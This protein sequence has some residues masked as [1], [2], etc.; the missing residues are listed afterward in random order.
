M[1]RGQ[2]LSTDGSV[3]HSPEPKIRNLSDL[4]PNVSP[5]ALTD[6]SARTSV[7]PSDKNQ[8]DTPQ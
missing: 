5:T 7:P 8:G 2:D 1:A 6:P 3:I 4:A